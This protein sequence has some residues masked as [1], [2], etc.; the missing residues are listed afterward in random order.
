MRINSN[1]IG[2]SKQRAADKCTF[3]Y[4]E[5]SG[6]VKITKY[7]IKPRIYTSKFKKSLGEHEICLQNVFDKII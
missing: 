6:F 3:V 7:M 4:C 2:I 1:H 5:M